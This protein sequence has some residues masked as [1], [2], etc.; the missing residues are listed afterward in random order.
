MLFSMCPSILTLYFKEWKPKWGYKRAND[1]L[2]DWML[3]VPDNAGKIQFK[4]I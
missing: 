3:E 2:Q 1:E 4:I